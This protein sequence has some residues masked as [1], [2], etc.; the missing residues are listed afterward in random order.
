MELFTLQLSE[1]EWLHKATYTNEFKP[2]LTEFLDVAPAE[3]GNLQYLQWII[4][5][6]E[7]EELLPKKLLHFVHQI[8]L[9]FLKATEF[10][11]NLGF[12]FGKKSSKEITK[13]SQE[14]PL[15]FG[16]TW[17]QDGSVLL[18]ING[19]IILINGF[20]WGYFTAVSGVISPYLV[21]PCV[22][23]QL[24]RSYTQM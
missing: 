20:H 4:K 10:L 9:N 18:V 19:A 23:N 12:R 22:L 2:S 17:P 15:F 14:D 3:S 16:V 24:A 21:V 1:K 13:P 7:L 5:T 6:E 11:P 8:Y